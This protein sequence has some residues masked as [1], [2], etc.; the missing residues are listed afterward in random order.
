MSRSR[1]IPLVFCLLLARVT[2]AQVSLPVSHH[3]V[4]AA[5]QGGGGVVDVDGTL[6][7]PSTAKPVKA[8]ITILQWGVG[9]WVY[10]DP[11]WRSLANDL[12]A[13]LL[14]LAVRNHGGPEDPLELPATQQAVRN[15]SLG[16]G[17]AVLNLLEQLARQTGRPELREAKLLFWGH[18]AAGSFGTSF[19][20]LHPSRTIAFVRYHS[21]SRNMPVDVPTLATIPGLIFA[22]E[23]DT[24]AG[25]EDSEVLWRSGRRLNAP[26][27]FALE[28]GATHGSRDA[29]TA[30][31][32]LALPWV[33]TVF[34]RRMSD[35]AADLRPVD[36]ST[37]WLA[38]V[39]GDET[40]LA[41][42]FRGP[43]ADAAW[44][45]DEAT[46]NGWRRVTGT[47]KP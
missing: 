25:V 46:V 29:L 12:G 40:S 5:A 32:Q 19:A 8:I 20:A 43:K 3:E 1:A 24:T 27:T 9:T 41:R 39:T 30:A 36:D 13:G 14:R 6:L 38:A 42:S 18:S 22:G 2:D 47:R 23:K 28:P 15:A 16:G 37:G 17:E 7:L 10:E 26:W 11:A 33:R 44:L 4:S 31:N 35:R 45:P 21:H 34:E